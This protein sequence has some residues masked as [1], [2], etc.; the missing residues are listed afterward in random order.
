[1]S[2]YGKPLPMVTEAVLQELVQ[3]EVVENKWLEYKSALPENTHDGKVKFLAEVSSFTNTA[4][5]DL[6]IGIRE[7]DRK[8]VEVCGVGSG[9]V[10]LEKQRLESLLR[11]GVEPRIPGVLIHEVS[12]ASGGHALV[13]RV[14]RS[15]AAPHRVTHGGHS[16]FYGRNSGGKYQLDVHELRAAFGRAQDVAERLNLWRLD[17]LTKIE[18]AETPVRL[19][20]GPR[21]VLHMIPLS[22]F[23]PGLV[24]RLPSEPGDENLFPLY[25][26]GYDGRPNFDGFVTYYSPGGRDP[27][28]SYLQL[29]R[30]GSIETVDTL[31]LAANASNPLVEER[32]IPSVAL[33]YRLIESLEKYLKVA[34]SMGVEPPAFV[35]L[36]LMGVKGY[37]LYVDPQFRTSVPAPIDRDPLII[38]ATL[39]EDF[40]VPPDVM[41]KPAFDT[42]WN[43]AGYPESIHYRDGRRVR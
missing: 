19:Q 8:P 6:V 31:L 11:D 3:N 2:I 29:F 21:L 1:M 43:A 27:R 14:Q 38:P 25:S 17:R 10:D 12:L 32:I 22:A 16:H 7:A 23:D 26:R 24:A 5:G 13:L 9:P 39:V 28:T 34:R 20:A 35:G 41:L 30:N 42:I 4:G 40:G 33:E 15:W 36:T 37:S 18:A